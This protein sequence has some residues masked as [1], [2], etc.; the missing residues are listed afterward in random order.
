[1]T[2]IYKKYKPGDIFYLDWWPVGPRFL[3]VADPE[4][5]SQ[6][7][8]TGIS[9]DKSMLGSDYLN[10]FLGP[11]IVTMEGDH[12]KGMR[13][14]F[15]PGFSASHLMTLMPY[16]V[17][18]TE[19]L[20]SVLSENARTGKLFQLEDSATRMTI[21][22]IGKVV[23][24]TDFDSQKKTHP[25]VECFRKRVAL[26]RNQS[27][28]YPWQDFDPLR[29]LKLWLNMRT[30]DGLVGQELDR[31]FESRATDPA[32]TVKK[33]FKERKKSVIDLALDSYLQP[34][35]VEKAAP[36]KIDPAVRSSIINNMKAF[37]F[38]GH[39]T[40]ATAISYA[41]Y[42]LHFFPEVRRKLVKE[43]DDVYGAGAT[44][45]DIA[46]A[47]KEDPYSINKLEY[48]TAIVKES[49]RIF[50]PASTLRYIPK[51]KDD[52]FIT[53]PNTG[54]Q[55]PIKG[56]DIWL[57]S[58]TIHRNEKFFPKPE[59]FVPERFIPSQTPFPGAMLHTPAGKD[60]WRPFEKGPR[61]CIGQEL[62]MIEAKVALAIIAKD[63]DFVA[64]IDGV[65]CDTWTPID[66]VEEFK[67]GKKPTVEGHRI[68]Q[69]LKGSAK[70]KDG[71]PGRI[72]KL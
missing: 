8:T 3:I 13:S 64:E 23:L 39:D 56:F 67:D 26:M 21:D 48:I 4:V 42:L 71:M 10:Q 9:L 31:V 1:M 34:S 25:I 54:R 66:T 45:Q 59:H 57:L 7:V 14:A 27:G 28:F 36:A 18:A 52:T 69:I 70:P 50:P 53:D 11:N 2:Y 38:A 16:I 62:A 63:F 17:D 32:S 68:Y 47:I 22:V 5:G 40:T 55:L 37:V 72:T 15:N 65:R 60:A 33:S 19:I 35:T 6:F 43:L 49:L 58:H 24:D 41:I 30:L 29:P 20:Y 51:N 44:H 12:W 61:N 46:T